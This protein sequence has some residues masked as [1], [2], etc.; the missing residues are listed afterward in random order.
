MI[1]PKAIKFRHMVIVKSVV[2][3]PP[4]FATAHE[5]HMAQSAQL[6][7]HRRLSH[8]QLSREVANIHFAIKQ[9]GNDAQARWV[10]EGTE[11]VSQVRGGLFFE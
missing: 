9:N 1:E 2:D 8:C 6:M 3:L 10:T 11:Q 5:T 4:I 7:R